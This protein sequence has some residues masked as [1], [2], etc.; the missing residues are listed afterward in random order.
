MKP[1]L[2]INLGR[3]P[4]EKCLELQYSVLLARQRNCIPDCLLIVEHDHV[5]TLG[6]TA[7][8][9]NLLVS[10]HLLNE[11][12]ILCI[13]IERGGDITYHGP[14]QLVIYPIFSL[15]TDAVGFSFGVADFISSLEDIM[16]T[17]LGK[18]GITGEKNPRNR[19]VWVKNSK[20]GFVG[21]AVKQKVS[22]H[23]LA[24]NVSPDLNFFNMIN[25][26]GME[27]VNISSMSE[28]KDRKIHFADVT[29]RAI[30][31]IRDKFELLLE[32]MSLESLKILLEAECYEYLLQP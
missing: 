13:P 9:N 8:R 11:K 2:Q 4:Y 15:D 29:N 17:V 30:A 23:G 16:I 22:F 14:G 6:K 26:C 25:P 19:G 20:V 3:M 24:L 10:Q 12:G 7:D 18:Y 5:F 31:A 1:C 28:Y 21:I 32:S 27:N